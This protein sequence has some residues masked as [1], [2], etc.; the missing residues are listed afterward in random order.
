M[1]V[2]HG[3]ASGGGLDDVLADEEFTPGDFVRTAKQLIDLLRQL[4]KLAPTET[5]GRAARAGADA[6]YRDL[7]AASSMVGGEE[8]ADVDEANGETDDAD[9]DDPDVTDDPLDPDEIVELG[10]S[11]ERP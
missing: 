2:A 10:G 4:A 1:A 11:I 9:V 3:W 7:V 5:T 6:V 8:D